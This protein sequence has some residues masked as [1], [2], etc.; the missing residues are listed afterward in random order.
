MSER[1]WNI[2]LGGSIA[3]D[4]SEGSSDTSQYVAVRCTYDAAGN[5]K[6]MLLLALGAAMQYVTET[7]WPPA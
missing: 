4:V 3:Q 7:D 5:S 6:E 2:P 1:Y